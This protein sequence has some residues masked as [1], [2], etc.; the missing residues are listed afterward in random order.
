MSRVLTPLLVTHFNVGASTV[1]SA[2]NVAGDRANIAGWSVGQSLIVTASPVFQPMLEVV[3]A[4]GNDVVGADLTA[5]NEEFLISP[6]FR[7]AIN[8]ASGLQLVPGVAV[9][10]GVGASRGQRG[11]FVYLSVE[12]AFSR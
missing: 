7:G 3:Y 9:P 10:L 8:F 1:P 5:H 11:V 2:R 4:R 12:H 6:G